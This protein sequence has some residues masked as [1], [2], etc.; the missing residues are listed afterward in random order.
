MRPA[1]AH[2][3]PMSRWRNPRLLF[4]VAL[5]LISAVVGGSLLAAARDSTDYW[6]VRSDVRSGERIDPAD[7]TSVSARV[8]AVAA[9]AL[10]P[11]D[12]PLPSGVWARDVTAGTMITEDAVAD[13][14]SRGRQ[15]PL[16]VVAGSV[17]PGLSVGQRVDV[18]SGPG[19]N[20]DPAV[21]A[22]RI[23][24][25]ASVVSASHSDGTGS[26]TIVVD[27][28]IS[29]PT[30]RVVAEAAAGHLTLVRVQ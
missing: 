25:A 30:A 28:G 13:R 26:R 1:P 22:R 15:L 8:D 6:M 27:T 3:L 17:P 20:A 24:T 9:S 19:P 4:G 16:R 21:E 12:G 23:L 18:W 2:R 5:V 7:L 10:L 29:G 14:A 11:A